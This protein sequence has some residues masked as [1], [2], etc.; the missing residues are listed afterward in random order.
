MFITVAALIA[1]QAAAPDQDVACI[2]D[3]IPVSARAAV[4]DEAG[5]GQN[6]PVRQA[7]VDAGTECARQR[8]WN[9]DFAANVGM[10]A[11]ALV[12]RQVAT[13]ALGRQGFAVSAIDRWIEALPPAQRNMDSLPE[14]SMDQLFEGIV[15]TG[16]AQELVEAHAA[17]IGLYV[18]ARFG[19]LALAAGR[20]P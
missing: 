15:A 18:G 8:S 3:R 7:F 20:R 14:A 2:V 9:P 12:L 13:V 6:G 4:L 10:R 1:V 19:E 17:E 16:V 11:A 5:G